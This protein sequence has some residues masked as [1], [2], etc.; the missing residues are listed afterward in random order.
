MG[1]GLARGSHLI[2][3]CLHSMLS[4]AEGGGPMRGG[5]GCLRAYIR[6]RVYLAS[7]IWGNLVKASKLRK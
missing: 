5:V 1:E 2:R 7:V 3:I 6:K 4:V